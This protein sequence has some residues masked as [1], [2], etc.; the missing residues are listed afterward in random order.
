MGVQN[1][2]QPPAYLQTGQQCCYDTSGRK[3]ACRGSGQDAEFKRGRPWPKPRFEAGTHVMLDHLTALVWARDAN[4]A[5]FPLSW[6]EALEF[7]AGMN[8]ERQFG[9]NDWRLPNRR[10]LRSLVSHQTKNP[11][12]PPAHLF[13]QVFPGWYWTSTSAA[14]SPSHAWY[15]HMGG[16]RMFFGGKDQAFLLWPVR[17]AANGS[18]PATGQRH[19]YAVDGTRIPCAGSGQDGETRYGCAWPVPRFDGCGDMVTDR[20]TGLVWRR[21]ADLTGGPVTWDEALRAVAGLNDRLDPTPGWRLP[22]INELESLVDCST[23]TPALPNGAPFRDVREGYWS[24]STSAFE[25]DW[26]WALYLDKGAVG[27]GQKRGPHFHVW[28]VRDHYPER[29]G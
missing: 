19:C 6:P 20:L 7:V 17:G 10:E 13:D 9:F 24:S 8:R 26:A 29:G 3:I 28:P 15:V 21:R 12:L 22:N 4:L 27:V 1:R 11:P 2:P 5:G 23:H 25:P 14:V 18:L 16:A